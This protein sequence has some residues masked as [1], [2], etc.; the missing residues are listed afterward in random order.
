M[1]NIAILFVNR[2]FK[3]FTKFTKFT[4]LWESLPVIQMP[5]VKR[6]YKEVLPVAPDSPDRLCVHT[7][8]P[9]AGPL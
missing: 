6:Q 3:D 5:P 2:F 9:D 7:A 4:E 8:D 1:I